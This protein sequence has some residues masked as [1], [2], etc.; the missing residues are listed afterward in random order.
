M[1]LKIRKFQGGPVFRAEFPG[2]FEISKFGNYSD[3][4][5]K[6]AK[7]YLFPS[8]TDV[9]YVKVCITIKSREKRVGDI[10]GRAGIFPGD[11]KSS[12]RRSTLT[13]IVLSWGLKGMSGS[14][15]DRCPWVL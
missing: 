15:T 4:E 3:V 11:Q 9:E 12:S 1:N 2:G 13:R 7:L 10:S 8:K 6:Q 5:T 14:I